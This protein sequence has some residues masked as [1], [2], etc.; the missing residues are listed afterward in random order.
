MELINFKK[1]VIFLFPAKN[2][3][4]NSGIPLFILPIY[5]AIPGLKGLDELGDGLYGTGLETVRL[6][7]LLP[8]MTISL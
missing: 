2:I 1:T 4:D 5:T 3:P 7:I 6:R 8:D